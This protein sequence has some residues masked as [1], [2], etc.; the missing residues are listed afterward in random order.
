MK[1][2]L[3]LSNN[4]YFLII[5]IVLIFL[6]GIAIGY[7]IGKILKYSQVKQYKLDAIKRSKSSILGEVY[8]KII[9]FLPSFEYSPK[10]MVFI[11]KGVDYLVFNG[12]SSGELEDII[13]LEIKSGKSS[14][15]KN[16]K[17]IQRIIAE[18]KVRYEL[19]SI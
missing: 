3:N 2:I 15:N 17:M 14:Q 13:F 18:K 16:E 19:M 9:P 7:V 1:S 4:E 8:E 6:F 11:G 5:G 10:D 12:L